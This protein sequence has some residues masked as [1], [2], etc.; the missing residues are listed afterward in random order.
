MADRD[1][2]LDSLR[3]A[4]DLGLAPIDAARVSRL[5]RA[6]LVEAPAARRRPAGALVL[7]AGAAAAVAV[8]VFAGLALHGRGARS[9]QAG[10][11]PTAGLV[12]RFAVLRRP[13]VAS[14]RLPAG[15]RITGAQGRILPGLTRRLG[16]YAGMRL[17]LVVSTP[18]GGPYALWSPRLGD[19]AG[20]LAVSGRTGQES[21][22]VPAAGLDNADNVWTLDPTLHR[23]GGPFRPGAP[24]RRPKGLVVGLIPDGVAR[25][26][27]TFETVSGG[28]GPTL[29]PW[30]GTDGLVFLPA[31]ATGRAAGGFVGK[32]TWYAA[33]GAVIPTSAA[34]LQRA[35][36]AEQDRMRARALR[37]YARYHYRPPAALLAEFRVFSITSRTPVR[38]AGGLRISAPALADLPFTAVN[39]ADPRQPARLDPYDIRQVSSANGLT[40][41][42]IPG[43]NG[44]CVAATDRSDLRIDGV[45]TTGGGEGCSG[46]LDG[47]ERDGAGFTSGGPTI[48]SVGGPSGQ[49]TVTYQIVPNGGTV[50]VHGRRVHPAYGVVLG[51]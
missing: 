35:E 7:A 51:G 18:A 30:P 34:A 50:K 13:Q 42:V 44:L 1:P 20:V 49:R 38:V 16:T 31:E 5:V 47:A 23:G 25:V 33:D 6:A 29:S 10:R 15:I 32:G 37:T 46:S 22:P 21:A 27:W 26:R 39:F 14:D 28:P 9:T 45:I 43:A 12:A 17:Y 36:T 41:W 40:M 8:A 11:S 4:G 24:A 48:K 19:Q 3:H 2:V